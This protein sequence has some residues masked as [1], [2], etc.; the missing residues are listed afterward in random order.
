MKIRFFLALLILLIW[1]W[2]CKKVDTVTLSINGIGT[3][4][5]NV[6]MTD[7]PGN[8]EAVKID[9]QAVEYHTES[10][11][12]AS[13]WEF[14]NTINGV[15]DLL[16]LT[17]GRDT[18]LAS[19]SIPSGRIAQLRLKIG[20][21]NTVK[22]DGKI[23]P[24]NI[25]PGSEAGLKIAVR[26]TLITGITYNYLLDFDVAKSIHQSETGQYTLYPVIR[27]I[28]KASGSIRGKIRPVD[29]NPKILAV[30]GNQSSG[31]FANADGD[32]LL[33]GLAAGTYNV[34]FY[35]DSG[36]ADT[37]VQNIS[38]VNKQV[39]DIGIISL[40]KE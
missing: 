27:L 14:I 24:L 22:V 26:D 2:S 28:K 15:Y 6:R 39:A 35:S 3:S 30:N 25:P 37:I 31:A 5:I 18:L 7:G 32:F 4:K 40:G 23:Y 20:M 34:I 1:G 17:N 9:L 36:Y 10:G 19:S 33:Q 29:A 11:S 16:E 12:P 8:Y 21:N 13:E 38:V